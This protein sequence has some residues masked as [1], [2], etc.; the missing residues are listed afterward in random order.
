MDSV[1]FTLLKT[2][3]SKAAAVA[4]GAITNPSVEGLVAGLL[5]SAVV[6]VSS[7]VVRSLCFSTGVLAFSCFP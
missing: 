2:E 6:A 5:P 4:R 1:A 3:G 7:E